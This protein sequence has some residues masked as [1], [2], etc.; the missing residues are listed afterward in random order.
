MTE[1][2]GVVRRILL[3]LVALLAS[4][5]LVV[6]G[7][8]PAG[9]SGYDQSGW[10]AGSVWNE[11]TTA[12]TTVIDC[13]SMIIANMGTGQIATPGTGIVAGMGVEVDLNGA[14]P[15][16]GESFYIHI[17]GRSVGTPCGAE[18]FIPVFSL[19][20]GVTLDTSK[21]VVCFSDGVAMA[22]NDVTCPQP[23]AAGQ[24]FQSAQSETGNP[25][26]YK[27][28]CGY[29]SGCL[30]YAWPAAYGHGFE[31]GIPVK[32][33]AA[34]NGGQVGGGAWVID[35]YRNGL[36]ALKAP[37]NVFGSTSGNGQPPADLPV[38]GGGTIP[39]P[40]TA[41]RIVYDNPSTYASPKFPHNPSMTSTYGV[42]STATAYTNGVEGIF[43]IAR[44]SDPAKL[45]GLSSSLQTL[46][47]QTD[48]TGSAGIPVNQ[49]TYGSVGSG[50]GAS[51]Q[52]DYDWGDT[53]LSAGNVWG[54]NPAAFTAGTRYYWKL[55]FAPTPGGTISTA[56]VTWGAVQSF[57]APAQAAMTCNGKPVTVSIALGQQPTDGDDVILGTSGNDSVNAGL[58]NDTICGLG[59]NDYLV[60]G[61]GN[62][63]ILGGDGDD[64]ML[65]GAGVDSAYGEGGTDT[66]SYADL[67]T[68]ATVGG[69]PQGG[70]IYNPAG[71]SSGLI[72][73]CGAAGIDV[74]SG[75]GKGPLPERF[76]GSRFDDV[77]T[78][79]PP[80]NPSMSGRTTVAFGGDG[81]DTI[82]GS[83]AAETL[84]GGAGQDTI[85]A[86]GGNDTIN[87]R[88][89]AVDTVGCA[90]GV[91]TVTADR[92]DVLA[93]CEKVL[94]PVP[95]PTAM[96]AS[97][98]TKWPAKAGPVKKAKVGKKL[99]VTAPVLSAA[100]KSQHP[101]VSY[102]WYVAG[103]PVGGATKAK[104]KVKKAFKRKAIAVVTTV[105]KPGYISLT[106]TLTFGKA[107]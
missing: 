69:N 99:K 89:G 62:D 52:V 104:F 2:T 37:L 5:G 101:V 84:I 72:V 4:M 49:F 28:L 8:A 9:A 14:H 61:P 88:D 44:D 97:W 3:P 19:P 10:H 107:R 100:A 58:G 80:T 18:G 79:G 43:V 41:Y 87:V 32:A 7:A 76:A 102:Q 74:L 85:D 106:R 56:K 42:I 17:W 57:V 12:S 91:D 46:S 50:G 105:S 31:F 96:P 35:P 75:P 6:S 92:A 98:V 70:V 16:V 67:D 20:A 81:N 64:V 54:T 1:S 15:K 33:T 83:D 66:V 11:G 63:V 30:S 51:Y 60:G 48:H 103:K 22:D 23:G 29:A 13:A 45:A 47:D 21:K 38:V 36:L 55:G 95:P 77:I 24:K 90:A 26:S 93:A 39:D 82:T 71:C 94:L 27:I 65:P 59:G 78:L 68:P 53:D 73:V 25:N 86:G 34:F 40:G